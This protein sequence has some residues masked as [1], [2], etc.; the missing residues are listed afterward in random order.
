MVGG[1]NSLKN[2]RGH[3]PQKM[4]S[5]ALKFVGG[6]ASKIPT[7]RRAM[8]RIGVILA[9]APSDLSCR[10]AGL[11]RYFGEAIPLAGAA[12]TL[13]N[14]PSDRLQGMPS[15]LQLFSGCQFWHAPGVTVDSLHGRDRPRGHNATDAHAGRGVVSLQ[16]VRNVL[17]PSTGQ[18]QIV[19]HHEHLPCPLPGAR[20]A[21]VGI[22]HWGHVD[23][24]EIGR[25]S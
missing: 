7:N 25:I 11:G 19:A 1:S 15:F 6:S 5:K 14:P 12:S 17:L 20:N 13:L 9:T 10:R 21:G 3:S 2:Q 8:M 22:R 23:D 4:W 24:R 16:S 18:L